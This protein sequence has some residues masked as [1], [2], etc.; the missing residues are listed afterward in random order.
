M[1][2][3][4]R[5]GPAVAVPLAIAA[6]GSSTKS[7]T[8]ITKTATT[9][10]GNVNQQPST[11]VNGQRTFSAPGMAIH[12]HYPAGFHPVVL[13]PSGRTAGSNAK[14]THSAVAL[15]EYD[16]LIVS[17]YPNLRYPVTAANLTAVK[18]QFDTVISQ[19]LGHHVSGRVGRA[20]GLPA[21][22]WPREPVPGLPVSASVMIVNAFVGRDEYEMQCQA[23]PQHLGAVE[24]A[25]RE[26]IATLTTRNGR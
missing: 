15:G 14:A 8:T 25:C 2:L 9:G 13:A 23:T 24:A 6:C 18:S 16:L 3:A 17:R 19:V 22:F 4:V 10:P 1:R 20:G 12:F 11:A 5:I 21:I 7:T 26:M